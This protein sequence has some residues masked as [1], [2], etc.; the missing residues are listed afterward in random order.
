MVR[1]ARLIDEVIWLE[2]NCES[3]IYVF[4]VGK[5]GVIVKIHAL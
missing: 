5:F 4:Y 3:H 1:Q 2:I